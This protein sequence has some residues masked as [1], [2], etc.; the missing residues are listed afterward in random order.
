M[1]IGGFELHLVRI[2]A[3]YQFG[4]GI[5]S[6]LFPANTVLTRS[7]KTDRIRF[8]YLDGKRL[9]TFRPT[10][11]LFSLS[12]AG[13]KRFLTSPD[14]VRCLVYVQDDVSEFISA[15]GDVFAKHVVKADTNIR[16]MDEVIIMNIKGEILA[17][18]RATLSGDEMT[19]FKI[20][21]AV[22]VRHGSGKKVK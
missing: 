12:I 5:G 9:A 3:D 6:M 17:V 2:I 1:V 16:P 19:A 13:A 4:K 11:G 18:G 15:G 8:I 21:V 7:R 14:S 10:D 22:K 20:G